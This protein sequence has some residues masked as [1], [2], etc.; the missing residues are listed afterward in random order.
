M[1]TTFPGLPGP[2]T[3]FAAQLA[4]ALGAGSAGARVVRR[5]RVQ[6][7]GAADDQRL[8]GGARGAEP[9][10]TPRWSRRATIT[11]IPSIAPT[12][13]AVRVAAAMLIGAWIAI[14]R[15]P[16]SRRGRLRASLVAGG[17]AALALIAFLAI[18]YAP[19]LSGA[20]MPQ[21]VWLGAE[22]SLT[23]A[24]ARGLNVDLGARRCCSRIR[25]CA[26]ARATNVLSQEFVVRPGPWMR[27]PWP[28]PRRGLAVVQRYVDDQWLL[29]QHDGTATA[30]ELAPASTTTAIGW[31]PSGDRFALLHP[32]WGRTKGSG[33]CAP[34]PAGPYRVVVLERD[35]SLRDD[36][37]AAV[38]VVRHAR[39][40]DRR[41]G[42]AA[43]GRRIGRHQQLARSWSIVAV[44]GHQR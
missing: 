6:N 5:E 9:S 37:G 1:L 24:P 26:T 14:G 13:S 2:A 23:F 18:L 7:L 25:S 15:A 3:L 41:R 31:S 44:A 12:C 28:N 42:T 19:L 20:A 39:R 11:P 32:P 30:I 17:I 27:G 34:T 35:Q 22:R 38:D 8:A 29:V 21:A 36:P 4:L 10:A 16:K 40:L 33:E 43:G